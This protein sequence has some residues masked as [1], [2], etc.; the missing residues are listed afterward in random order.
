MKVDKKEEAEQLKKLFK[1]DFIE[2]DCEIDWTKE[3]VSLPL[4][5]KSM[6]I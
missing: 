3:P 4:G 6:K 5:K 1:D 2:N